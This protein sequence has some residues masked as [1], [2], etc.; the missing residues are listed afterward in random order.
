MLKMETFITKSALGHAT[1]H[2]CGMFAFNNV[3]YF[4]LNAMLYILVARLKR[5]RVFA[6]SAEKLHP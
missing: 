4:S 5:D 3:K 1:A 6:Y 2:C